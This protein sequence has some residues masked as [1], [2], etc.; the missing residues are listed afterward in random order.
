MKGFETART[1]LLLKVRLTESVMVLKK[2]TV[3]AMVQKKVQSVRLVKVQLRVSRK[4]S[5]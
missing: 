1:K 3:T 5:L 2:S 4:V